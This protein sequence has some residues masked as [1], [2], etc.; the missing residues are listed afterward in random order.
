MGRERQ[1]F[2]SHILELRNRI[3]CSVAVLLLG[4]G[5]GYAIHNYLAEILRLPLGEQLYY[6]TPGG[7]FEFA[8]KISLY[9]GLLIA[10]PVIVYNTLRFIEPALPREVSRR[11][12]LGIMTVSSMLAVAG[13]LFCYYLVLPN[14]LHFFAGYGGETV[15]ALISASS[16]LTFVL[17]CLATFALIFQLPLIIL[18]I[19]RI[20]PLTPSGLM[21]LQ[22]WVIAGSFGIAVLLP[23]AYD[24]MTQ[25]VLALPIIGLFYL[26][27]ALVWL[28][29]YRRMPRPAPGTA[30]MTAVQSGWQSAEARTALAQVTQEPLEARR[31]YQPRPARPATAMASPG[32][33]LDLSMLSIAEPEPDYSPYLLDVRNLHRIP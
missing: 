13:V 32:S 10:I 17:N 24:P 25:L 19:N 29:N 30:S 4:A 15:K 27:V 18:V 21:K 28:A 20:T 14:A 7:G 31:P 9:F 3:F 5:F 1:A 16:Y 2:L 22:R 26:S 12:T 8:I 6:T 11:A 23:F 33:V